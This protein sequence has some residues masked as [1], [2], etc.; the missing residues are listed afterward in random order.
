ME[1][2]RDLAEQAAAPSKQISAN[3]VG[4]ISGAGADTPPAQPIATNAVSPTINDSQFAATIIAAY[5]NMVQS[6]SD[7]IERVLGP[8]NPEP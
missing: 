7:F 1:P 4:A 3:E 2:K 6:T 8:Y 5:E